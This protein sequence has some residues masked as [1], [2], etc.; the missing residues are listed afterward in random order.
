[1]RGETLLFLFIVLIYLF[2]K[3]DIFPSAKVNEEPAVAAVSDE[4]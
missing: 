1:M 4:S 3:S 2:Y